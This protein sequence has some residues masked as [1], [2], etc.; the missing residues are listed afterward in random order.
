MENDSVSVFSILFLKFHT[1]E[2]NLYYKKS[3]DSILYCLIQQK[4]ELITNF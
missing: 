1:L 4:N 2:E 3:N